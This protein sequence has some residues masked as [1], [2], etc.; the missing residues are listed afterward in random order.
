MTGV[1]LALSGAGSTD[2]GSALSSFSWTFGDGSG[3]SGSAV[4]HVYS[5]AGTYSVGLT[6]VDA[7]GATS[8]TTTTIVV[9][10]ARITHVG[11]KKSKTVEKLT[12]TASGP[13]TVQLG[14][15]KFSVSKP[16]SI[17]TI[18]VKLSSAQRRRLAAGKS[19]KLSLKLT[20]VPTAGTRSSSTVRIKI[21]G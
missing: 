13:G 17:L 4:S 16:G 14:K 19:V 11:V 10:N 15:K 12:V 20:F 18:K 2:A 9:A 1:P 7:S 21:K 8:T 3:G 5:R 6:V